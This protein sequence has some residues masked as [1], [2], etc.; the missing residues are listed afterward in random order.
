M[1]IFEDMKGSWGDRKVNFVDENNVFVGYEMIQQCCEHAGW[2]I[3]DEISEDTITQSEVSEFQGWVF[4]VEFFKKIERKE[5]VE[6]WEKGKLNDDGEMV[7]FRLVKG[8][9]EKF[10]HLFN[11]HNGFYYHG[12]EFVVNGEEKRSDVL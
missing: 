7:I 11:C 1:K 12:F 8:D 2:F 9:Q 10:L 6:R 4:D 3:A 5:E